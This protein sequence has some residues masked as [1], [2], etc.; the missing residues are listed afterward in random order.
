MPPFR[1]EVA[2]RGG[3]FGGG[4]HATLRLEIKLPAVSTPLTLATRGPKS[5]MR[6][7]VNGRLALEDGIVGAD[8]E[9]EIP[10]KRTIAFISLNPQKISGHNLELVLQLSSHHGDP[11]G[12]VDVFRLGS[13][14]RMA[15]QWERSRAFLICFV[16]ILL[17]MGC[18]HLSLFAFRPTDPS[19]LYFGLFCLM[20]MIHFASFASNRWLV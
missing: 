15:A 13:A 12:A 17:L 4:K 6:L 7:W 3:N 9:A 11:V 19:P 8:R 16:T 5:A 2:G 10:G 18:Y 14:T 20:W 1:T